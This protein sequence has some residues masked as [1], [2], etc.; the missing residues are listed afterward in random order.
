MFKDEPDVLDVKECCRLLQC[1]KN[2]LYGLIK[3]NELRSLKPGKKLL[4][5]KE[6][7]VRYIQ[8]NLN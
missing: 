8:N 6:E 1:G 3:S 7:V 2:R 5:P 4:V